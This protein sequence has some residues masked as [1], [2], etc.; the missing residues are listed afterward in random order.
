MRALI[1]TPTPGTQL[2]LF[3]EPIVP[4]TSYT[5]NP[6]F[7]L[8]AYDT[9]GISIWNSTAP[10]ENKDYHAGTAISPLHLVTAAHFYLGT[11][12]V[13]GFVAADGTFVTRTVVAGVGIAGTDVWIST[14]D[15]PLPGTVCVYP[16]FAS[17]AATTTKIVLPDQ[18][19]TVYE[20]VGAFGGSA[21]LGYYADSEYAGSGWTRSPVSGDSGHAVFVPYNGQLV[22]LAEQYTTGGGPFLT[23]FIAEINAIIGPYALQTVAFPA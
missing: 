1:S 3:A 9:S 19:N 4:G 5:R 2:S 12:T 10:A 23:Q 21:Y 14:L 22:L 18:N 16:V 17:A 8:R 7:W 20:A 15:A 11:G 13:V 6:S